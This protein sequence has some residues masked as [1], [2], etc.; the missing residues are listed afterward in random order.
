VLLIWYLWGSRRL[1]RVFIGFGLF[2]YRLLFHHLLCDNFLRHHRS[3][4]WR[5]MVGFWLLSAALGVDGI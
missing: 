3:F 5:A 1:L 4:W 2:W